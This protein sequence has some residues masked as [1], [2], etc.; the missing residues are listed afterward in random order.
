MSLKNKLNTWAQNELITNDQKEKILTFEKQN[1]NGFLAKTALIIAGLFIGL[2][3]CL[4]VASNWEFLPTIVKFIGDFALFSAF[5]YGVYYCIQNKKEHFKDLFLFLSFLMI[6]ATIGLTAQTFNLSGGWESFALSWALLSIPYVLLSKSFSFNII[7]SLLLFSSISHDLLEQF[8]DYVF[9]HFEGLV[10]L[11]LISSALAYAFD[12]LYDMIK[13]RITLF[14]A[15]S[16]LAVLEAY[17][18][19]ISMVFSYGLASSYNK[20]FTYLAVLFILAFLVVRL[21]WAFKKQD[22]LSFKRNTFLLEAYIFCFF[23][24][25]FDDLLYSGFGFIL[26]GLFILLMFYIFKK[27]AKYI[28]KLEIFK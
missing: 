22:M 20:D 26:S 3:I 15:L 12:M 21:F 1:N 28:Q 18:A 24:S 9:D 19:L 16:K 6:A 23:A 8:F 2:G 27:T 7:W 10:W 14:H 5:L 4:I 11:V 13:K 17:I 25:L